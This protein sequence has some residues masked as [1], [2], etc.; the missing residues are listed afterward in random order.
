MPAADAANDEKAR[1]VIR[2]CRRSNERFI[3]P[4]RL[5]F[6]N[7]RS[8]AGASCLRWSR[9]DRNAC[10]AVIGSKNMA[11]RHE[12]EA[13]SGYRF[14]KDGVSILLQ[15]ASRFRQ[16]TIVTNKD[17]FHDFQRINKA[18]QDMGAYDGERQGV[19]NPMTANH[20]PPH[21]GREFYKFLPERSLDYYKEGSF[22]FGSI[23]YYRS[24]EQQNS[25]DSMEGLSN[26][27]IKTPRHLFRMSLAS[28]YNFALFCGT[29]TLSRREQMSARFGL[30]LGSSGLLTCNYLLRRSNHCWEQR[31]FISTRLSITI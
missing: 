1:L 23:Q 14:F 28:G 8:V 26:L 2:S 21:K 25:K 17:L 9:A 22:Q 31:S 5:G 12:F 6:N 3:Q 13:N 7:A 24:V 11:I 18:L 15:V 27:A 30:D 29:S 16:G 19:S 20:F 4:K 10:A